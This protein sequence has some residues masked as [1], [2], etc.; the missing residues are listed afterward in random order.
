LSHTAFSESCDYFLL[1]RDSNA[2]PSGPFFVFL[3]PVF[4]FFHGNKLNDT[5]VVTTSVYWVLVSSFC[6]SFPNIEFLSQTPPQGFL[7]WYSRLYRNQGNLL[8][9]PGPLDWG[10]Q[11]VLITGGKHQSEVTPCILFE[12][13]AQGRLELGNCSQ[14]PWRSAMSQLSSL[15]SCLLSQRTVR[16][17]SQTDRRRPSVLR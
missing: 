12:P 8:F 2:G 14:I 4:F 17:L 6:T 10:E 7:K 11:I 9:G 5:P 16:A 3:L 15:T 13:S 1:D